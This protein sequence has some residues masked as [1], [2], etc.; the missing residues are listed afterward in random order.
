MRTRT[1]V[2][3]GTTIAAALLIY[4]GTTWFQNVQAS[5]WMREDDA[6]K[7]AYEKT[8]L[9]SAT[10]TE[11]FVGDRPYTIV[12]G[13]DKA[14]QDV[15]VWVSETDIHA[16]Y[17]VSGVTKEEVR[18]KLLKNDPANQPLRITLGK[19][20]DAYA[21][22]VFYKR[23]DADGITRSFYDYYRFQDGAL[24]DTWKLSLRQ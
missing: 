18:A 23:K 6:V 19:L 10:H 8:I 5:E 21:W 16:E 13:Q 11:P 17:A 1:K 24:I 14:G 2:A 22:E 12:Y 9:A 7:T 15:I 3:I 20:D 4:G